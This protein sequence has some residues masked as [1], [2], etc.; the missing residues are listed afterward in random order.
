MIDFIGT[1]EVP[2]PATLG[3]LGLG[4]LGLGLARRKR[5]A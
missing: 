2:E 5:A 3:I 1:T 4:L